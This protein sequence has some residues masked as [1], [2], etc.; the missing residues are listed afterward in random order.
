MSLRE[1]ALEPALGNPAW[2]VDASTPDP[3][4]LPR[5]FIAG[6]CAPGASDSSSVRWAIAC[7]TGVVRMKRSVL[8]FSTAATNFHKLGGWK[9]RESMLSVLEVR[10]QKSKCWRDHPGSWILRENPSCLFQRWWPQTL[11]GLWLHNSHLCFCLHVASSS[12]SNCLSSVSL[13]RTLIGL[14]GPPNNPG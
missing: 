4:P 2:A 1:A 13:I 9:P 3:F 12:S 14:T 5:S 7:S 11:R 6:L 10:N 8:F